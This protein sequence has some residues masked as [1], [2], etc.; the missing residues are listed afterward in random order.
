MI[1]LAGPTASGKSR[2]AIELARRSGGVV[3]NADS[4]QVY[5]EFRVLTAR[6]DAEDEA[7]APHRLYGHVPADVRYS[8][9]RWFSDVA[10][11]VDEV[12][13]SGRLPILVGGTGLYFKA[14][15]EGLATVPTVPPAVRAS[16]RAEAEGVDTAALH[17]RLADVDPEDAA[18]VRPSDRARILRALDVFTATGR[19]LAD[20]QQSGG[21][22]VLVE[23]R[24]A[25]RIVLAPPRALLHER[26]AERAERI[27]YHGGLAEVEVLRAR[28]L[29]ADLPAMKAIGVREIGLHLDGSVSL[30]EAVA[31]IKTETRR[32]AKR[33][34]TWFRN[35]MADWAFAD[36]ARA[37]LD[38]LG[39][40]A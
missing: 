28:G 11:A 2:L 21:P 38:L 16:V 8:V 13:K 39:R 40:A 5:R 26:I 27:V 3:I 7:A 29:K 34:M 10:A 18:K 37:V 20:W 1:L 24:G 15:V 6:P 33:Q 36:S 12:K 25:V 23:G 19:S 9:G 35:Q 17:T 30:D 14:A 4:M 32:Y 31:A 22:S